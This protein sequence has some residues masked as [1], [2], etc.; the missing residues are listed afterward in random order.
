MNEMQATPGFY[1]V[2]LLNDADLEEIFDSPQQGIYFLPSRTGK[3][4]FH[5]AVARSSAMMFVRADTQDSVLLS[6]GQEFAEVLQNHKILG[7][8]VRTHRD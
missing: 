8:F 2:S 4:W 6:V 7:F 5:R 1:N 3:G